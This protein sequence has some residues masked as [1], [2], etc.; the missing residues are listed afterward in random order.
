MRILLA[1]DDLK[2][3]KLIV[4]MLKKQSHAADWVTDGR[5]VA[6]Y[7][8][9]GDYDLLI[10]DWMLPGKDGVTICK[11]LREAGYDK[12]ILMLTARDALQDRVEGLDAG[13]DDYLM[14]PFEFE[15][16]FARI[17]SLSRRVQMPLSES[18]I[19]IPPYTLNVNELTL[20]RSGEAVSLTVREFQLMETLMRRR[21]KV[22]PREAL[23]SQIWGLDAEV[24]SNSL[25]ALIKLLRK[26][27]E[28]DPHIQIQ[29]VRGVGY[30][31]EVADVQKNPQ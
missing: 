7:A 6:D 2:L 8:D 23:V 17:R 5:E 9:A 31:L 19:E 27:L 18:I 14:K 16:L 13:A 12:G 26:K 10:L 20:Y 28:P 3:G 30:K 25:D 1:E 15:E 21:G 22:I 24:T 11:E 29:N 4:H